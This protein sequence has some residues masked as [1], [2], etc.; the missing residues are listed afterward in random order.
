GLAAPES[1]AKLRS[2]VQPGNLNL[3]GVVARRT[4]GF[5]AAGNH[6]PVRVANPPIDDQGSGLALPRSNPRPDNRAIPRGVAARHT[7]TKAR[8]L[9]CCLRIGHCQR[10]RSGDDE[11]QRSSAIGL[12]HSSSPLAAPFQSTSTCRASPERVAC[13]SVNATPNPIVPSMTKV[14]RMLAPA[15]TKSNATPSAMTTNTALTILLAARSRPRRSG[16]PAT[17]RIV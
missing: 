11:A 17:C 1:I 4:R 13:H 5:P 12:G 15:S 9:D 14:V 8:T 2:I 16:G 6:L 7:V 10:R 3:D